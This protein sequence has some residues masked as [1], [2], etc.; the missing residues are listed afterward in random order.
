MYPPDGCR[1]EPNRHDVLVT[2]APP[3]RVPPAPTVEGLEVSGQ[4]GGGER[5]VW[6]DGTGHEVGTVAAQARSWRTC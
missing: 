1:Q 3:P 5:G 4:G 2:L 6:V